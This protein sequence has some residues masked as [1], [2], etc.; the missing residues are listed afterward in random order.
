MIKVY[1][2]PNCA[3][4]TKAKNLLEQRNL[5]YEY[6]D[7]SVVENMTALKEAYPLAKSVPQIWI[8]G[9]HVGGYNQ[10]V[11]YLEDTGYNGTGYTL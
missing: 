2:K 1:G 6:K 3:F 4:C 11:K 10:L 8:S 7:V 9:T 5:D